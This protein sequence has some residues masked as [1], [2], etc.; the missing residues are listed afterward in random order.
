MDLQWPNL[1]SFYVT[2]SAYSKNN[3]VK[4]G[5]SILIAEYI[6]PD[7][8]S[9][10]WLDLYRDPQEKNVDPQQTLPVI[11]CHL[12]FRNDKMR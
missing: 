3:Y 5:P 10:L 7:P 9:G 1:V 6:Y 11:D 4:E 8:R 12:C 2:E